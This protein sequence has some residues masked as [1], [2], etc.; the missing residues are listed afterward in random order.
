[1]DNSADHFSAAAE[2]YARGRFGYPEALFDWLAGLCVERKCAWDCATGS[3]QAAVSLARRFERVVATDISEPLL[4]KALSLQTVEYRRAAAEASGL[5]PGSVDL[6][7]VAQALHWFDQERFWPELR[8]VCKPGAVFAFWGYLWPQVDAGVDARLAGLRTE[9]APHWPERSALLQD[10]Y[11]VVRPPFASIEAPA[12]NVEV[13][14]LRQDYVAHI[15]SWSAV[16][17][18]RERAGDD[19]LRGFE[20]RLAAVWPDDV[21]RK[22][23]WS[24]VLRAFRV[25]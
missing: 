16:R 4:A 15:A 17:Y 5:E 14:W 11:R 3:G 23:T 10:E 22:V 2:T 18:R 7:T 21:R 9:L 8:R 13:E 12:F 1:M 25:G 6:V 20:Q 24:L 19:G